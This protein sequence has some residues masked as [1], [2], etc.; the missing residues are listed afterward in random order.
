V[1]GFALGDN[2]HRDSGIGQTIF[3]LLQ[4]SKRLAAERSAKVP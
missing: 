2:Q 3:V 1:L 4:L